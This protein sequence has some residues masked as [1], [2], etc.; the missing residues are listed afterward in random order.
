MASAVRS[1]S[2]TSRKP[3]RRRSLIAAAGIAGALLAAAFLWMGLRGE[4][5][6]EPSR[7]DRVAR[8]GAVQARRDQLATE[9]RLEVVVRGAISDREGIAVAGARVCAFAAESAAAAT[10]ACA[11]ADQQGNYELRASGAGHRELVASARGFVPRAKEIDLVEPDLERRVDFVLDG[12]GAELRGRVLDIGGGPV[13]GAE[14]STRLGNAWEGGVSVPAF[15]DSDGA[16]ALWTRPGSV[17]LTAH[18]SGYAPATTRAGSPGEGLE[19]HLIP[20]SV[21]EGR[22]V[23]AGTDEPIAAAAVSVRIELGQTSTVRT[24]ADGRFRIAGL[25]PGRYH[26]EATATGWYGEAARSVRVGLGET[27]TELLIEAHPA[28]VLDGHIL[29]DPDGAPCPDGVVSLRDDTRSF[30]LRARISPPGAAHFDAILPG[31]YDVNVDCAAALPSDTPAITIARPERITPEWTVSRGMSVRGTVQTPDGKAAEG[32]W[33]SA[34]HT[35]DASAEAV[36][37]VTSDAQGAFRLSG[38]P[39]GSY[40]L[41]VGGPH[42]LVGEEPVV[43]AS[44]GGAPGAT[45]TVG[46]L[47]RLVG[48]VHDPKGQPVSSARVCARPSGGLTVSTQTG[49][50]GSFELARLRPGHFE[51]YASVDSNRCERAA[52]DESAVRLDVDAGSTRVA[53]TTTQGHGTIRGTVTNSLGAPISDAFVVARRQEGDLAGGAGAA[54]RAARWQSDVAPVLT[55]TD[56]R[57]VLDDLTGSRYVVM[58]YQRGGGETALEDVEV[59]TTIALQIEATG[60][61]S[62]TVSLADGSAPEVFSI[63]AQNI[64]TGFRHTD[65]FLLTGGAWSLDGLPAGR[66]LVQAESPHASAEDAVELAPGENRDGISLRLASKTRVRGQVVSQES[67]DPLEGFTVS[68]ESVTH[69][70]SSVI[71]TTTS[72]GENVTGADGWFN[73]AEAPTGRVQISVMP[74]LD[75]LQTYAAFRSFATLTNEAVNT[76]PPIEVAERHPRTEAGGG[77]A[78]AESSGTPSDDGD[79]ATPSR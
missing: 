6:G 39:S 75:S 5:S 67:G 10:S 40:R 63:R 12:G 14:V 37:A 35:S 1:D 34:V 4:G 71:V 8:H 53:L 58:A 48:T 2:M 43:V 13:A 72:D 11:T 74:P 64:A 42:Y 31:R 76:L 59:D 78:G 7:G 29:Y 16:F 77:G 68:I 36:A 69:G 20:E 62:G 33:V 49:Q 56:G 65:R 23:A 44:T 22:V 24:D 27:A 41:T 32:V 60:S 73:V 57:F 28:A 15:T 46:A 21:I 25:S 61:I 30:Y 51:V 38:L 52:G 55:D 26:A 54:L 19:L 18:A 45:L 66:F 9:P 79:R 47:A 50:D 17:M 70:K 3:S